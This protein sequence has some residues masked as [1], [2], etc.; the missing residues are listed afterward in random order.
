MSLECAECERDLRGGHDDDCVLLMY[1]E[2]LKWHG[3]RKRLHVAD[4]ADAFIGGWKAA[5]AHRDELE[6]EDV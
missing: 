5:M 3:K 4:A 2:F 6:N 1:Q